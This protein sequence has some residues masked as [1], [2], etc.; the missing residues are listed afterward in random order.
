MRRRRGRRR[1]PSEGAGGAGTGDGDQQPEEES[2]GQRR[3]RRQEMA[4][5][6]GAILGGS[7]ALSAG[8][9]AEAD[10]SGPRSE[11]EQICL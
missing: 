2:G 5:E 4:V 11:G 6:V 8:K 10:R 3:Q 1:R 7:R 9:A